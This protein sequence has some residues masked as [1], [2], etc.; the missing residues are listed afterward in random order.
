MN[1]SPPRPICVKSVPRAARRIVGAL[2]G[3]LPA[4]V[5]LCFTG[6]A[7][8]MELPMTRGQLALCEAPPGSL[9]RTIR[10]EW[11]HREPTGPKGGEK[12][13]HPDVF[14]PKGT[15][16]RITKV[17]NYIDTWNGNTQPAD[18]QVASGPEKGAN[19]WD[20][21]IIATEAPPA[22]TGFRYRVNTMRARLVSREPDS[23]G[24]RGEEP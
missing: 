3:V 17:G 18:M 7:F 14:L 13:W 22:K 10:G 24:G 20:S 11:Y 1:A 19:V 4:V 5:A 9:I 15:L 21:M 8:Q 12:T 23:R 2:P 16:L 6:C